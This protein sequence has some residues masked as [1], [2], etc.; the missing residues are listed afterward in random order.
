LNGNSKIDFS[1]RNERLDGGITARTARQ[2]RDV[3]HEDSFLLREQKHANSDIK[4]LFS[5]PMFL[6][7]SCHG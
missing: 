5:N 2:E 7:L 6:M 4:F 3:F 1:S